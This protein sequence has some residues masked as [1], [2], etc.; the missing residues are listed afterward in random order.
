MPT[1]R[2]AAIALALLFGAGVAAADLAAWDQARVTAL[3]KQLQKAS[4]DLYT[5]VVEEPDMAPLDEAWYDTQQSVRLIQT[6]CRHLAAEL[7]KGKG[8][9][10]TLASWRAI[11]E[12]VDDVK[13]DGPR[14]GFIT[15]DVIARARTV[16]GLLEQL[17]P[18]YDA[19][20][21]GKQAP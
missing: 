2:P 11:G 19:S 17:R 8:R 9:A 5:S 7:A 18:F 10:Q 14:S 1:L 12:W 6:E 20:A 21:S 4:E 16:E 15:E 3:A 13:E